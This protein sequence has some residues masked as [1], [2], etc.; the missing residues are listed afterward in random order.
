MST[1]IQIRPINNQELRKTK[2]IKGIQKSFIKDIDKNCRLILIPN[3]RVVI[4]G[5]LEATLINVLIEDCIFSLSI[6]RLVGYS[7]ARISIDT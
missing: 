3:V 1:R 2:I 6:N 4:R 5:S 7:Q